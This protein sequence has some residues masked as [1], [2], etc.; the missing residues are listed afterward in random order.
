M[1]EDK[2]LHVL[3]RYSGLFFQHDECTF[4]YLLVRQ[5]VLPNQHL[6][7]LVLALQHQYRIAQ[8]LGVEESQNKLEFVFLGA[9]FHVVQVMV[10]LAVGHR[11]S[12]EHASLV[13]TN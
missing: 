1:E 3:P 7:S 8:R 13:N 6:E 9:I 11:I 10:Y 5:P 2:P 4:P 12:H